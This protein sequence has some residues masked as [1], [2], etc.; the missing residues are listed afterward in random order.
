[1]ILKA[2][3]SQYEASNQEADIIYLQ[4]LPVQRERYRGVPFKHMES[5]FIVGHFNWLHALSSLVGRRHRHPVC[6]WP[7]THILRNIA[8]HYRCQ[9]PILRTAVCP[10]G[11]CESPMVTWRGPFQGPCTCEITVRGEIPYYRSQTWI[12]W[13]SRSRLAQERGK[14]EKFIL[15]MRIKKQ[16]CN[17]ITRGCLF[18][19]NCTG[20]LKM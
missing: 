2:K 5:Q 13:L 4:N 7:W 14:I 18:G 1:M 9:W 17:F 6:A 10:V 20:I 19:D 15:C 16:K 8:E 3:G 11:F 12:P